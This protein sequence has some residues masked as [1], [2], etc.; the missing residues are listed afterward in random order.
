MTLAEENGMGI[1]IETIFDV[2]HLASDAEL[3]ALFGSKET[4]TSLYQWAGQHHDRRV[5]LLW[6]LYQLRGDKAGMAAQEARLSDPHYLDEIK[7]RD[8]FVDIKTLGI[9]VQTS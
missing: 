5:Q 7:Y 3:L 9:E 8:T 1:T 6:M 2:P 4:H